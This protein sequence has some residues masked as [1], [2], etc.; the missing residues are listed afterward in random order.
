MSSKPETTFIGSVHK[1]L[2]IELYHMKNNN[3]YTAGVPDVWYSGVGGDLWVEYKFIEIP[4]R[5]DT[6]IDLIDGKNP[7]ISHLQQDWL[8]KRD[9]QGRDVGV[10]VGCKEG[11]VWFSGV[12]WDFTYTAAK[13]RSWLV[14][15]KVLAGYI[16]S[17]VG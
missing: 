2:P 12:T 1:H 8:K 7:A 5:P 4:K 15:R 17:L 13:F 3:P 9:A 16:N 14:D 6:V 11:G 10:I